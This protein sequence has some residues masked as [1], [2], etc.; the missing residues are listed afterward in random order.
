MKRET[1]SAEQIDLWHF[2]FCC[3]DCRVIGSFCFNLF[4][5]KKKNCKQW[6]ALSGT[7]AW[8]RH[9]MTWWNNTNQYQNL[10]VDYKHMIRIKSN[11]SYIRTCAAEIQRFTIFGKSHRIFSWRK[12]IHFVIGFNFHI[13]L[14]SSIHWKA[15]EK[16]W[17]N[18]IAIPMQVNAIKQFINEFSSRKFHVNLVLIHVKYSDLGIANLYINARGKHSNNIRS[19]QFSKIYNL[20]NIF[21][22][23]FM[24]NLWFFWFQFVR[25][26]NVIRAHIH[27]RL[28]NYEAIE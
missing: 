7:T 25:N 5:F 1:E 23:D 24:R 2:R 9:A 19:Y 22:E 3:C 18:L 14:W 17:N 28:K 11:I 16:L 27:R 13:A 20:W 10:S 26:N 6:N 8:N 12:S 21:S 15:I 4:E